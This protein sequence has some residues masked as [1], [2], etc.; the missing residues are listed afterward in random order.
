[1]RAPYS[2]HAFKAVTKSDTVADPLG[3]FEGINV[4]VTGAVKMTLMDGST[5]A[6]TLPI[7][8]FWAK[9]QRVW[10]TGTTATVATGFK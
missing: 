2:V 8:P 9:I 7:G 4:D 3:P 1:M 10:S 5:A 6:L